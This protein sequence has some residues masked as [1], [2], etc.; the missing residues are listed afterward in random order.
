MSQ[1]LTLTGAPNELLDPGNPLPSEAFD[2]PDRRSR[3]PLDQ[4]S[5]RLDE[6]CVSAVDALQIAAALEAD[7][8]TDAQCREVYGMPD[9]FAVAE[10]LHRRVP[11]RAQ[12]EEAYFGHHAHRG[13]ARIVGRGALFALPT[14]SFLGLQGI[15]DSRLA[16]VVLIGVTILGWGLSQAISLLA[17]R[18]AGRSGLDASRRLLRGVL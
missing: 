18:V 3:D 17:H 2:G 8:L 13:R 7:G 15:V 12:G 6:V 1:S 5:R 14:V 9:V 4:L 11:L 10:E 16:T